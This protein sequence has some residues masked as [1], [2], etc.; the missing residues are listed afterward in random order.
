MAVFSRNSRLPGSCLSR[1]ANERFGGLLG[2]SFLNTIK[3]IPVL[4]SMSVV[5]VAKAPA[6]E[7]RDVA[8]SLGDSY[9][10][11]GQ[12]VSAIDDEVSA[13]RPEHGM[14]HKREDLTAY[15]VLGVRPRASNASN[16]LPIQRSAASM[17]SA[18]MYS[19]ISSRSNSED[20]TG[21]ARVFRR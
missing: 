17:L 19:Q 8:G 21:H 6:Q 7:G 1:V 2:F 9:D 13:D 5:S 12:A 20:V 10:L 4:C 16:S 3:Y 18:A 11:D 14:G 15:P